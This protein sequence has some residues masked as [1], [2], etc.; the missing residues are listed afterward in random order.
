[1]TRLIDLTN[2]DLVRLLNNDPRSWEA[3]EEYFQKGGGECAGCRYN[4]QLSQSHGPGLVEHFSECDIILGG[5]AQLEPCDCPAFA[6]GKIQ[7][8]E[9][10]EPV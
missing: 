1:M 7:L 6:E 10:G 8:P 3:V 2:K 9:D 4:Q 5:K